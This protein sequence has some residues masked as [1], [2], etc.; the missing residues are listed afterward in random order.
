MLTRFN[1]RI[2]NVNQIQNTIIEIIEQH[3]ESIIEKSK[4]V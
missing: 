4:F 2:F 1:I 3:K